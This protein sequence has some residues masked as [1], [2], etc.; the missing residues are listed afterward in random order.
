MT[1]FYCPFFRGKPIFKESFPDYFER[2]IGC[3]PSNSGYSCANAYAAFVLAPEGA[4]RRISESNYDD[5][6]AQAIKLSSRVVS[7]VKDDLDHVAVAEAALILKRRGRSASKELESLL[8]RLSEDPAT[9]KM[10]LL[11]EAQ[12]AELDNPPIGY[13]PALELASKIAKEGNCSVLA[14]ALEKVAAST[15][16]LPEARA[17]AIA[18]ANIQAGLASNLDEH[19]K[20]RFS[21]ETIAGWTALETPVRIVTAEL[22]KAD[23]F[24]AIERLQETEHKLIEAGIDLPQIPFSPKLAIPT[25]PPARAG[26]VISMKR[27]KGAEQQVLELLRKL[28][29]QVV[30]VTGDKAG[31][32]FKAFTPEREE[33]FI[34]VKSIGSSNP[35]FQLTDN[36]MLLA[37]EKGA[38]YR[39]ALVKQT[40]THLQV[41]FI[42]DP[43]NKLKF[44]RISRVVLWE[45]AEHKFQPTLSCPLE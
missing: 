41:E 22:L 7:A 32:D 42:C 39:L 25:D 33:T 44:K 17:L 28:G 14:G 3:R 37:H 30:D 21:D 19:G 34:E 2:T 35:S 40:D 24:A 6:V 20:R 5:N 4:P 15:T 45:C 31:C 26:K 1:R 8:D 29:W 13:T 23:H 38:A 18:A 43:K 10:K 27:W 9:G 16:D 12:S 36:E 11:S